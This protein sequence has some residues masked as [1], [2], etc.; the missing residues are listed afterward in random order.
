LQV[1]ANVQ[2]AT[3]KIINLQQCPMINFATMQVHYSLAQL[4]AFR[5]AVITI[6]TFDG[7]HAGHQ[8]ILHQLQQEAATI[9]GETVLITFHPHPRS[10][11][12]ATPPLLL[13]TLDEKLYL[14]AQHGVDHV[15]IVP[16]NK[17]FAA[18]SAEAYVKDFLFDLFR[19]HT[20]IIGYDHR[21]GQGR[22]GDYRLLEAM[23]KE[24]GFIVKEIP[25]EVIE[26]ATISSTKIREALT[27]GDV[28]T[29]NRFLG[30]AYFFEGRVVQGNQLG[31][32]IGYPT[33]N[34]K[35]EQ[36]NKL[37]PANGVYAV[38][39]EVRSEMKSQKSKVKSQKDESNPQSPIPNSQSLLSSSY[40]GMM[41]IGVR[42]TVDGLNKV[43]EVNIFDFEKDIYGD[44]LQV[45]L[46]SRLRDEQKFNG[47]DALKTQLA[48]DK[49][50]A[51]K[52]LG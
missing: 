40:N 35:I 39:V 11:L 52:I 7:V 23:G 8:K 33:A 46:I 12:S 50:N 21:F 43:T 9:A 42:P 49:L 24:L 30:Y 1:A 10:V 13:N 20:L 6:G 3:L 16:F 38:R 29:A 25:A 19:P 48:N 45:E 47:L 26:H 22:K 27:A 4:P 28:Q 44:I 15:V 37:V 18:L 14:L 32:T 51:M 31:R 2:A 5:N 34:L 41:N 36:D 17:E